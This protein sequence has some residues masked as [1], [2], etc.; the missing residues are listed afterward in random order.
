MRRTP[1]QSVFQSTH[2]LRGATQASELFN[3]AVG[4]SIHAPLA[5]C[6]DRFREEIIVDTI[7]IHAPLAGC[8]IILL[9]PTIEIVNFNPR[10][11]CGVR[12]IAYS[13]RSF[14]SSFQSTHPLRGATARR[15]RAATVRPISIHAPLAGCDQIFRKSKVGHCSFQ[16]THPLRGATVLRHRVIFHGVFQSTH[17]LRGATQTWR[18]SSPPARNF[19]PRTPC[20]VRPTI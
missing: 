2:P 7:S 14:A 5:G 9:T 16:S 17:P 1:G 13:A 8:D 18:Q 10:T 19:N 3:R 20:G 4:I 6:D 11:P 12:P 15:G